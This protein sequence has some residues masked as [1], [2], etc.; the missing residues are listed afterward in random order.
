MSEQIKRPDRYK[1]VI[2]ERRE[3]EKAQR[4]RSIL[5]AAE[6]VFFSKGYLK[7]T[8]DEIALEAEISKPTIYQYFKTKDDLFFS[9]MLPVVDDIGAL[10]MLIE[11]KVAQR[12]YKSGRSLIRDVFDGLLETYLRAPATFRIVQ[13]FQQAGLVY[14]LNEEIQSALNYKGRNNFEA[15][16]RSMR[17]A[18]GQR[19]LRRTNVHALVDVVWGLFTGIVQI[20]DIK[21]RHKTE[22]PYLKPTLKLAQRMMADAMALPALGIS[23]RSTA[24]LHRPD[25]EETL[26]TMKR[27]FTRKKIE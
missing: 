4:I 1:S 17:M 19:L 27:S 12:R 9:L 20:Q 5:D 10:L 2:R 16:R 24:A 14:E 21:S 6:K 26:W 15:L 25:Q 13:M 18:M 8:M 7:A 3:R 11:K 23:S 22:N